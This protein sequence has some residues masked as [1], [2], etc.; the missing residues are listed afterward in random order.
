MPERFPEVLG[1]LLGIG[2]GFPNNSLLRSGWPGLGL[3]TTTTLSS[4]TRT[5]QPFSRL[6]AIM[7]RPGCFHSITNFHKKA[8]SHPQQGRIDFNTVN[9]SLPTG[10]DFLIHPCRWID[11]EENV[12]TPPKLGRY[13]EIHPLRPRDFPR[14]SRFPSG[15]AL[16]KSLGSREISWASGM[17]FPIPPS[18]WWSTDTI[19]WTYSVLDLDR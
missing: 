15:F 9:P 8:F 7:Q 11:D 10:M 13:W 12:R 1:N 6:D 4:V 16:G 17:D 19:Y 5:R 14:P 2:D 3:V 18:F